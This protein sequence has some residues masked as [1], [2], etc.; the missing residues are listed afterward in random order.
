[1]LGQIVFA[2]GDYRIA[3]HHAPILQYLLLVITSCS[4]CYQLRIA[5]RY[6]GD[7]VYVRRRSASIPNDLQFPRGSAARLA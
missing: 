5:L 3:G 1:M 4:P 6:I 7:V 2:R